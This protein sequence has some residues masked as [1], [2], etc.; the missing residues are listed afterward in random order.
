MLHT[1]RLQKRGR[2][3]FD[4]FNNVFDVLS[5]GCV[6]NAHRP[7]TFL[8]FALKAKYLYSSFYRIDRCV[9]LRHEERGEQYGAQLQRRR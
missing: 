8:M 5:V 7:I 6:D 2:F 9:Y 4:I 3:C 1:N